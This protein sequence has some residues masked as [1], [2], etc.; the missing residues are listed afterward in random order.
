MEIFTSQGEESPPE[1]VGDR[2]RSERQKRKLTLEQLSQKTELSKS[3]LSQ[4]ERGLA[5]PSISSLKKI[6]QEFGISVVNFFPHEAKDQNN[7]GGALPP[8]SQNSMKYAEDVKAVRHNR[9]KSMTLPGSSVS[10]E[11]VSPDLHRQMEILYVRLSQG[12]SSGDA[13]IV[14]PPGEKCILVLKGNLEYQ[15]GKEVYQL[16]AGDSIYHASHHPHSWRGVGNDPIEFIAALT[17]PWF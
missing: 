10:Y 4:I 15:V 16:Q 8:I 2:I 3:F 14:D 12:D 7:W 1:N 9:R 5:Q 17:P 6:A 11:L 13:P